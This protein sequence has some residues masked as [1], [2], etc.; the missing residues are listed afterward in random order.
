M[1]WSVRR[2]TVT[3]DESFLVDRR[4]LRL[5]PKNLANPHNTLT[6]SWDEWVPEVRLLKLNES[7]FA[8]RRALLEAQTKKNRPSAVTAVDVAAKGKE[9][10]GAKKGEGSRKRGRDAGLETVSWSLPCGR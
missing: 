5:R 3:G 1:S 7:G 4:S 8:K 9:A 10:K 2:V 6:H